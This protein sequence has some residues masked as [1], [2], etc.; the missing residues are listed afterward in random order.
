MA[1]SETRSSARVSPRSVIRVAEREDAH[2]LAGL[3]EPVVEVPQLGSLGLRVPLAEV[4][5]EGHDALLRAGALLVP[6]RAAEGRLEAVLLER[7]EQRD[8]LQPVARGA[9]AGLLD[10]APAVDRVLDARDD[11]LRADLGDHPVAVLDHLGEVVAGVDVHDREGQAAGVKRLAGEV[12][13]D[14]RV[15]APGE[16][17]HAALQLRGHFADHVYGLRLERPKV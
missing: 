1:A 12:Q 7:V 11:Q 16:Q 6:A 5:A 4:V 9:R 14:R 15:L 3:D 2:V 10:H 8:G 17:Q 13:Q